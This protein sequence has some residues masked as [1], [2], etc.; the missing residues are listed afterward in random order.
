MSRD[1]VSKFDI[2]QLKRDIDLRFDALERRAD[3]WKYACFLV[4]Y[5]LVMVGITVGVR[6]LKAG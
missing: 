1:V 3:N 2:Q 5:V 4:L 6:V